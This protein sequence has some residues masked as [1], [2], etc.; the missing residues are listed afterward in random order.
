MEKEKKSCSNGV[1][2]L[3]LFFSIFLFGVVVGSILYFTD[4]GGTTTVAPSPKSGN[5]VEIELSSE[6]EQEQVFNELTK[7]GYKCRILTF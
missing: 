3:S 1:I 4:G 5:G 7:K 2:A 6:R